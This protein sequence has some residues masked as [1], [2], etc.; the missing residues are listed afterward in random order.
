MYK[1]GFITCFLLIVIVAISFSQERYTQNPFSKLNFLKGYTDTTIIASY[2]GISNDIS[3]SNKSVIEAIAKHTGKKIKGLNYAIDLAIGNYPLLSV[4]CKDKSMF[5]TLRM[6]IGKNNQ[7]R[8]K[9]T[10]YRF[11]FFDG[12][13]NFFYIDKASL[14]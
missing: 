2:S 8:I 12:I 6:N 4:A 14:L 10:V 1:R 7:I 9:C 5:E 11:Y 13:C 3:I